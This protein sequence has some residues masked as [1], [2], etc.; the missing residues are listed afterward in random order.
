MVLA[1]VEG[2][3]GV[4]G[5]LLLEQEDKAAGQTMAAIKVAFNR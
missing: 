1:G 5:A 3:A 2:G 4:E